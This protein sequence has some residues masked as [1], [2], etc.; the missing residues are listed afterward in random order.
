MIK[1]KSKHLTPILRSFLFLGSLSI[2]TVLSIG[3]LNVPRAEAGFLDKV[4]DAGRK[5]DPT[6]RNSDTRRI[7]RE[8]DPTSP[9][10][11]ENQWGN[12]GAVGY[13]AAAKSMKANNGGSQ[14]LDEIQK[15]YLR[16]HFG[17]LVD[18]VAIIYNANLTNELSAGG[19]KIPLKQYGGQTFCNR[20]YLDDPYKP[21]DREQR[22]L[23]AHELTHSKQC[24]QLGGEGKFGYHYFKEFKKAGQNY[25]NNKLEKEAYAFQAQFESQLASSPSASASV[26]IPVNF[27]NTLSYDRN[28]GVCTFT[29]SNG[30]V[31]QRLTSCRRT[32]H[33]IVYT[34]NKLL[35]Y[36]RAGDLEI[37]N[38]NQQG[39]GGR[40]QSF[41][42]AQNKVRKTWAQITSSQEGVVTFR[43]DNGQVENYRLNHLGLLVR[44]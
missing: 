44:I 4:R 1:I 31:T 15:K 9:A 22:I 14:S 17:G 29:A 10:F 35:F 20:I 33:S 40:L 42:N 12:A 2:A 39:L 41:T 37:Y 16:P 30:S 34:A 23:L 38:V 18:Q 25:E 11:A 43:D 7:L 13:P 19:Y 24:Q 26:S 8:N 21:N 3:L 27:G 28:S 5:I 6:N 32:W 36:D